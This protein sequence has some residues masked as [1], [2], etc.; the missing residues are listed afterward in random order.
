[1]DFNERYA[2]QFLQKFKNR[3]MLVVTDYNHKDRTGW[4]IL[5]KRELIEHVGDTQFTITAKGKKVLRLGGWGNYLKYIELKENRDAQK[6]YYDFLFSKY[7]Y[8]T[9]WVVFVLGLFG[10][11]YSL[12]DFISTLTTKDPIQQVNNP[13]QQKKEKVKEEQTLILSQKNLDSSSSSNSELNK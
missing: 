2:N 7:R 3:E 11:V 4:N 5:V 1:M 6:E 8:K 13:T 12:V 9:F 10:G